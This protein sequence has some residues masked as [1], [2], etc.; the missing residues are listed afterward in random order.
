MTTLLDEAIERLRELPDD[1]QNAAA[2]V[3][4]A[5][6]ASDDTAHELRSDQ[7]EE[8]GRIRD[9]LASGSTRLATGQEVTQSKSR[10]GI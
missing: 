5:Y 4:F 3:L 8:V 1:E 9:G 2:D 7:V 10:L 6:I